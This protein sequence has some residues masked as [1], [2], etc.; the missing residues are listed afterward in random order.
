MGLFKV[1]NSSFTLLLEI[2]RKIDYLFCCQLL[3][4]TTMTLAEEAGGRSYRRTGS[5]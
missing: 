5:L 4:N 3:V 1:T 2:G